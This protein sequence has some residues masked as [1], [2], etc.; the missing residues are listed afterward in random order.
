MPS[1]VTQA[2]NFS[3]TQA[4]AI[5]KEHFNIFGSFK[6]LPSERDQNFHIRSSNQKEYVLKIA[7]ATEEFD[8]LEFQNQAMLHVRHQKDLFSREASVCPDIISSVC[9]NH[10]E[11]VSSDQGQH[12]YI[13]LLTYLPGK[14][15]ATAAPH[16][17]EML[18]SLGRFLGQLD[19]ALESF[20]HPG[21]HR[22]FHWDLGRAPEVIGDLE[23]LLKEKT[24]KETIQFLFLN[25]QK[26]F[27]P[28]Q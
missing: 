8:A 18:H 10:V 2:P 12:H 16:D 11:I 23:H 24:E 28:L 20:D 3:E 25:L 7:N 9:G 13:R 14:P 4:A 15:F 22:E 17:A 21:V 1:V 6:L 26:L 19:K 5:A 27:L